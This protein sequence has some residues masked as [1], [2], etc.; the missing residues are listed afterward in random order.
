MNTKKIAS[1]IIISVAILVVVVLIALRF[2]GKGFNTMSSISPTPTPEP[3]F[4]V[5]RV[6][7]SGFSPKE[8]TVQK[9]MIVRFTHPLDTKINLHWDGGT[10][11]TT[12]AVYLGHDIATTTFDKEG[13]YVFSDNASPAHQGKITVK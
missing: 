1:L 7:P 11:Y 10:Q 5:I 12:E 3:K 2:G 8:V 6:L 4:E 9:G 13:T